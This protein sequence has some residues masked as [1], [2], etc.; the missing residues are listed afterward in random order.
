MTPTV[1]KQKTLDELAD[2]SILVS[3]ILDTLKTSQNEM[4]IVNDLNNLSYIL[5]TSIADTIAKIV[6]G[7]HEL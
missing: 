1:I 3:E 2:I 6:G 4:A 7:N 5:T